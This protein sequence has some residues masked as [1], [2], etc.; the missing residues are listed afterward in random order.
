MLNRRVHTHGFT[1]AGG[2]CYQQVRHLSQVSHDRMA[3]DIV[4]SQRDRGLLNRTRG[5]QHFGQ[6]DD[7]T[8]FVG[9]FDTDGGLARD[10][11]NHT[12]TDD[13][14]RARQIFARLEILLTLTPSRL[15][16][17]S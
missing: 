6:A 10:D 12:H 8:I 16:L 3:T 17:E 11:L 15:D 1:G 14:E 7:F 9:N 4:P 5:F 2:A 13:R